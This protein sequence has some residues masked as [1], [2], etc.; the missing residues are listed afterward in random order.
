MDRKDDLSWQQKFVLLPTEVAEILRI[1]RSTAYELIKSS[2][3]RSVSIGRSR[4]V[5]PQAVIDFVEG[6]SAR[7]EMK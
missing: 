2:Q 4:R 1:S 7:Q 5:P 3:I 6:R